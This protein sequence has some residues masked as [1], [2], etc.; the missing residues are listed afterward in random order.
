MSSSTTSATRTGGRQASTTDALISAA[1]SVLSSTVGTTSRGSHNAGTQTTSYHSSSATATASGGNGNSNA[2]N[3]AKNLQKWMQGNYP[4]FQWWLIGAVGGFVMFL[5]IASLFRGYLRRGRGSERRSAE[6]RNGEIVTAGRNGSRSHRHLLSAI[7][8]LWNRIF[9]RF[10]LPTSM[11]GVHRV[12]LAEAIFCGGYLTACLMFG[13]INN[14]SGPNSF[15]NRLGWLA[16]A[17]TPFVV[18]LAGKNNVIS[19]L[20][21]IGPERL[22]I[23]H[24]TAGRAVLILCLSHAFTWVSIGPSPAHTYTK[25]ITIWGIAALVAFF[26]SFLVSFRIVRR[27]CYEFFLVS[28]IVLICFFLAGC[29]MHYRAGAYWIYPSFALWGTDRIVR[30]FRMFLLNRLWLSVLS[31]SSRHYT[32]ATVQVLSEETVKIRMR[33]KMSWRP[34]QHAYLVVPGVSLMPFEAH[35]FTIACAPVPKSKQ[36]TEKESGEQELSFI[37]RARDGFTKRLMACATRGGGESSVTAFVDGGSGISYTFA[38]LSHIIQYHPIRTSAVRRVSFVWMVRQSACMSWVSDSLS[39]LLSSAPKDLDLDIRIF[40]TQELTS[41]DG[42]PTLDEELGEK[43]QNKDSASSSVESSSST[44]IS[45]TACVITRL[46]QF[47]QVSVQ[48]GRPDLGELIKEEVDSSTGPMSVSADS[49][50]AVCGPSSL[51]RNVRRILTT[52]ELASCDGA[53]RGRP[54]V[55]LHVEQFGW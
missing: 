53:L 34:G 45:G 17:Q 18:G 48:D 36:P 33:R 54:E 35:P 55:E 46:T 30:L 6:L 52:K 8:T 39:D 37:V 9:Y 38:Q 32:Q 1:T 41:L 40:V 44:E 49:D 26:L 31:S 51:A 7:S 15:A 19:Y 14:Q 27:I 47:E 2:Q 3:A 22:S 5:Y 25:P 21:G 43:S 13:F 24:R 10:T 23:L 20:T 4:L 12:N 11:D 16:M 42:V 28:H 50:G 29:I